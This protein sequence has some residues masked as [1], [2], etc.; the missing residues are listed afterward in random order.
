VKWLKV[1]VSSPY[2]NT[3]RFEYHEVPDDYD[4]EGKDVK[5]ADNI[6]ESAVW[7]YVETWCSVVDE[8][9]AEYK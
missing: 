8:V 1:G 4:P 2:I 9:P 3:E 5:S 6:I 7:E